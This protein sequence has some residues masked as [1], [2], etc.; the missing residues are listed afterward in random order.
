MKK[1][2]FLLFFEA[3]RKILQDPEGIY[4]CPNHPIDEAPYLQHEI[5]KF[6]SFRKLEL[7]IECS[8]CNTRLVYTVDMPSLEDNQVP[9][10]AANDSD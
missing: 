5:K 2:L 3:S 9:P 4:H 7:H 6:E 1:K 10:N 8:I